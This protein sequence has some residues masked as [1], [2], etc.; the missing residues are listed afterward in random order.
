MIEYVEHFDAELKIE[1]LRNSLEGSVLEERR[2]QVRESRSHDRV[3]MQVAE[4]V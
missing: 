4:Y 2:I 3:A 1:A